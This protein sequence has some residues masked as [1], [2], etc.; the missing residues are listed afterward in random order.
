MMKSALTLTFVV[1]VLAPTVPLSAQGQTT[2]TVGP[3]ARAMSREALRLAADADPVSLSGA[4]AE[5]S[6]GAKSKWSRVREIEEGTEIIVTV[7]DTPPARRHFVAADESSVTVSDA[8][9][10]P[11]QIPR[12]DVAELSVWDRR[13]GRG[14]GIGAA[15]GG[16]VGFVAGLLSAGGCQRA[17]WF[18]P[19]E[20]GALLGTFGGG[21]GSGIGAAAGAIRKTASVIYRAP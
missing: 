4:G 10:V 2:R 21:V 8:A 15:I 5:G 1:C 11:V 12:S 9:A 17:C 18:T 16:T 13:V 7:K 3:L 6:T 20:A 14:T 19:A